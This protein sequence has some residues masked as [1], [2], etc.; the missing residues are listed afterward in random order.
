ML[1]RSGVASK[2]GAAGTRGVVWLELVWERSSDAKA[3]R[4]K[5]HATTMLK[6]ASRS[7]WSEGASEGRRRG[8]M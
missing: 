8:V 1:V 3:T 5:A 7:G 6:T 4:S 2:K